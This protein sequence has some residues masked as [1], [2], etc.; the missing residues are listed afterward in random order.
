MSE[1]NNSNPVKEMAL[2]A[3]KSIQSYSEVSPAMK[4]VASDSLGA[5]PSLQQLANEIPLSDATKRETSPNPVKEMALKAVKSIQSFGEVSPA[6]RPV[7]SDSLGANPS[8]QAVA[9]E[10]IES[11]KAKKQSEDKKKKGFLEKLKSLFN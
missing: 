5:N 1:N 9:S 8:L 10:T 7:A 4:P 2:K 11:R 6:M 3:V